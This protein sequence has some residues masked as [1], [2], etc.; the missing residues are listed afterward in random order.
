MEQSPSWKANRSSASQEIPHILWN[1]KVHYRI[2]KCPPPVPTLSHLD[3]VHVATCHFL[4]I[5]LNIIL[6]STPYALR[7]YM[8]KCALV[9]WWL[10]GV[11]S[12]LLKNNI[13]ICNFSTVSSIS[14][15]MDANRVHCD[16]K[17]AT[18]C[19]RSCTANTSTL[20]SRL[21]TCSRKLLRTSDFT[22][23][24]VYRTE[25]VSSVVFTVELI[26]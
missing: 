12:W 22:C 3:P 4:K 17:P 20:S 2:H 8:N 23:G 26:S 6:P 10:T 15:V 9:E 13:S 7:W 21:L 19:L 1:M 16:D 14:I 24:Y 11:D 5:H 18:D 25:L